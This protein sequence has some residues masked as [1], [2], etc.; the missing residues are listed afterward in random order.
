MNEA[1]Q[2]GF[3]QITT[4]QHI[5]LFLDYDGTLAEFAPSPDQIDLNPEVI[6]LVTRLSRIPQLNVIVISGRRLSHVLALLPIPNILLAGTYGLEM[7][8]PDGN[9][10][11][12]VQLSTLHPALDQLELQWAQL[13]AG[14][15]GFYLEDKGWALALHAR[16]AEEDE[17]QNVLKQA[18]DM[19][20]EA[21]SSSQF[22]GIKG[23][24]FFEVA[25]L[26]ANKGLTVSYLLDQYAAPGPLPV[27]LGDDTMDEEAFAVVKDRGGIPIVVATRPRITQ[28]TYRLESPAQVRQWLGQ[29]VAQLEAIN[30]QE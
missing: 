1:P 19:A 26:L 18:A 15:A 29:L 23:T 10:I 9:R 13:I 21:I 11:D 7:Q 5:A 27:Y 30:P 3:A 4:A 2:P 16:Y 25:P 8:L 28:A 14:R 24:R 20:V 17:A 22:R 6:A 12:R